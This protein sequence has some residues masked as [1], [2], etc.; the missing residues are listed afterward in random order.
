MSIITNFAGRLCGL[1][2]MQKGEE[3]QVAGIKKLWMAG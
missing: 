2:A 1:D 3:A